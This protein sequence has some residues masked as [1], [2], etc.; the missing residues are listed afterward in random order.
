M[1]NS[2]THSH[3]K[4]CACDHDHDHHG[5]TGLLGR[6]LLTILIV[7][8]LLILLRSFI[9]GQMIVRVTSYSVNSSYND[10][11]RIC[12]KIIAI[13]KDNKQAW[14]SLGYAYMDLSQV[15]M[16][17]PA[18]EKVLSI[19]PQ[20]RGAASYELGQAYYA[21]GDFAKAIACF[22]RIR[23]AGPKAA[24]LLDAD[25]LKYR[26][27]T[28]GFRSVNSMKS[29]LG[30]LLECYQKTGNTAQAAE[31]EKEYDVYKSKHSKILF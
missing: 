23:N 21:K 18:F 29:L 12:K 4:D 10:A 1:T 5:S 15:D 11:I 7:G 25:I 14:T 6:W 13:D 22:E 8:V 20:D 28:L 24:A 27:G 16:A 31:I 17:I 9:V 3:A 2:H 30:T 19:D 26:H